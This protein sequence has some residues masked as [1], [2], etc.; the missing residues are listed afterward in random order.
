[1]TEPACVRTA[2]PVASGAS[3]HRRQLSLCTPQQPDC[4]P[5]TGTRDRNIAEILEI[6][7]LS[8]FSVL[9]T[10]QKSST[11]VPLP[12]HIPSCRCD[13]PGINPP[14]CPAGPWMAMVL[15]KHTMNKATCKS[16]RKDGSPCRQGLEP[17]ATASPTAPPTNFANGARAAAKP[18][19]PPP[20]PTNASPNDCK[21]SPKR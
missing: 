3:R 10:P 16:I 4:R 12:P 18:P 9:T 21:A 13:I 17:M 15:E 14:S 11:I 20:G 5:A 7:Q 2:T 19:P 6:A 1:M 8:R